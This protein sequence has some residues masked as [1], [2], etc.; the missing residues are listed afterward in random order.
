[1]TNRSFKIVKPVL[2]WFDQHGREL[3]WRYLHGQDGNVYHT[4]LSEIMLQQT[5]VKTVVP[6]FTKFVEKWPTLYDLSTASEDEV[7]SAWQGLGYYS[8]GRNILKCAKHVVT[9]H[10]GIFPKDINQL[11]LLPGVGPYTASALASIGHELWHVPVDGNVIR[12]FSRL[13]DIDTPLPHLKTEIESI[14]DSFTSLMQPQKKDQPYNRPGDFAQALMDIGATICKPKNPLCTDCPLHDQCLS[15]KNETH[16]DRPVKAQKKEKPTRYGASIIL[17]NSRQEI[18]LQKRPSKGLLAG[19]IQVPTTLWSENPDDAQ[20]D[21]ERMQGQAKLTPIEGF[22][23]H[24]FTHFHLKSQVYIAGE[25][26]MDYLNLTNAPK[27]SD[28]TSLNTSKDTSY[29][30]APLNDLSN[31]ALPTLMKKIISHSGL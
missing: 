20:Q 14:A 18:L 22:V 28:K 15:Y 19:M 6:Y 16:L 11:R 12:V 10:G 1:M 8:R 27:S 25:K 9:E 29:F 13:Y 24:T 5:G 26:S 3:P 2:D 7:L 4:W 31:Y 30:F 21:L 23:K 17:V